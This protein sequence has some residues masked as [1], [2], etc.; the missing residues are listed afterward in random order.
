MMK[1][2][3]TFPEHALTRSEKEPFVV[4]DMQG[5]DLP[6]GQKYYYPEY[7]VR[8]GEPWPK[9]VENYRYVKGRARV[10][11][12]DC[13][14]LK[15]TYGLWDADKPH[16]ITEFYVVTDSHIRVIAA[17]EENRGVNGLL[18][19]KDDD[20]YTHWGVGENNIGSA[21]EK[22]SHGIITCDA[23]EQ[24]HMQEE[25]PGVEDVVG[26]YVL[27]LGERE[28]DVSRVVFTA[29]A[30]QVSDFFF[31]EDGTEVLR[32]FFVPDTWGYDDKI[33]TLYTIRWA[34]APTLALNGI[35]RVLVTCVAGEHCFGG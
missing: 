14:E 22:T 35:K 26:R 32:R 33:N 2:P 8:K 25:K 5:L 34:H 9:S 3:A 12:T 19:F 21:I 27:T 10:H 13:L 28:Y 7:D 23:L 18:T 11:G 4:R 16:E 17:M 1:F 20:F 31:L 24:L 30:G 6:I 29:D 15:E